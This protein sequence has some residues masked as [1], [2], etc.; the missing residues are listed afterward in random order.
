[1]LALNGS[2]DVQ[3]LPQQNLA[4]IKV[5][6]EKSKSKKYEMHEL[7]GLNHLFQHCKACTVAEYGQLEETF[8][9]EALNIMVKWL[10]EN[11]K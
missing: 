11:V 2:K 8:A 10:N 6:L 5:A 7:P 3:V 4:A 1:M 9:P